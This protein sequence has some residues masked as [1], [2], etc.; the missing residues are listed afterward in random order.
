MKVKRAASIPLILHDPYFSIWSGTDKLYDSDTV[1]WCGKRQ[2][3]RGY[4]TIDGE[5]FCFMGD[6]EFHQVI[7]QTCVEITATGTKYTFENEKVILTAAFT[8]PLLLEEPVLVSRPCTYV[9]FEVVRKAGEADVTIDVQISADLVRF[10][11]GAVV[12]G[13]YRTDDFSYAVMGKA[14]Q[15]PL[16]HSGDNITIDW[17]YVYLA[18]QDAFSQVC[19]DKANE[20]LMASVKLGTQMGCGTLVAAYDDLLSINYFGDWKKAYWTETYATILDAVGASFAD[21]N[22][23]QDKCRKL[24]AKIEEQAAAIGGEDYA[25][26][27]CLSY[28]HSI[29]AHKLI[30]DKDGNLVFLSKE[31]D[32]NGCLGTVDVTYPS[33]PLYMLYNTEYVKGMLR[34]VF[35]FAAC[36]VWEFDFAPH[37]VGR[38][39]YAT[40]QVYGLA[41]EKSGSAFDGSNGTVFPFFYQYPAGSRIYDFKY[42]MP[43]EECG[44]MLILTAAVCKLDGS[45]DFAAPHMEVLK[46]WCEYLLTYGADPGEQLCTDDFAGHLSHNVNLSA[47]AIMGIEAFALLARQMGQEEVYG[48][49]H[50]KA[51]KMAG[52]WEKRADAG[53][54]TALSFGDRDSWSLKYNLVWDKFFGSGLF[55]EEVYRKEI[56]YYIKKSNVYGVPLDSRKEYTKSDWILW[57]A[58]MTDDRKKVDALIA[59]IAAYVNE[60]PSRVPFSDWYETVTGEYCHFIA[61]SV[62]GG[63]FMP[64]LIHKNGI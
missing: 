17:G 26:L 14:E 59:P 21:K 30:A 52:D 22:S 46:K 56:D 47:K 48:E 38:F 57:C 31:N 15:K 50:E 36:D 10:T 43:V 16:G 6:K 62:Q 3:I 60:T 27:C 7:P 23:V 42:Q 24:D 35:T 40:G 44:N 18:V 61:R 5:S 39:P 1:H 4:I 32:S 53:D 11:P 20:Q 12:G 45:P 49:Y 63:I 29:A 51:V 13:S 9:D 34:P 19:F 25:L 8:S 37:D 2:K 41:G 58:S 28:R 33:V 64:M 55:R 54:H